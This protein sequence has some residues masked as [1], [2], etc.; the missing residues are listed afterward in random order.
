MWHGRFYFAIVNPLSK[1]CY[2]VGGNVLKRETMQEFVEFINSLRLT[3]NILIGLIVLILI[4]LKKII[5]LR[6]PLDSW[7]HKLWKDTGGAGDK[8]EHLDPK[9]KE[10]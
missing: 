5:T 4:N 8:A 6:S 1:T 7:Q 2:G 3:G 10:I 9:D